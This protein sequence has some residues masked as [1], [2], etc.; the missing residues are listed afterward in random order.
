M[1]FEQ[2]IFVQFVSDR[3]TDPRINQTQ[4]NSIFVDLILGLGDAGY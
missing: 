1:E 3:I 4:Q 2:W